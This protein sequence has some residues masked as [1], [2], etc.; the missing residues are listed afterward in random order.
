[1]VKNNNH[2]IKEVEQIELREDINWQDFEG[3]YVLLETNETRTCEITN[4]GQIKGEYE[5]KPIISMLF[6]VM[7]LDGKKYPQGKKF[8][9][10]SSKRL[11]REL[12]PF[13]IRL[14]EEPGLIKL[15]ITKVGEK[16][17][18]NYLVKEV[19]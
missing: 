13:A 19:K 18:T 16:F 11:I 10:T 15:Q 7:E 17:A 9:R 3:D 6:D 8:I 5:G 4:P 2:E 14:I 1:M 12:K